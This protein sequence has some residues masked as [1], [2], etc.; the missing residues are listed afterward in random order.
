MSGAVRTTSNLASILTTKHITPARVCRGGEKYHADLKFLFY[1]YMYIMM[2]SRNSQPQPF[3]QNC[4][5]ASQVSL[6]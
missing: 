3:I 1:I 6:L 4:T 5:C 2:T